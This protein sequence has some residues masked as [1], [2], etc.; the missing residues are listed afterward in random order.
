MNYGDRSATVHVARGHGGEATPVAAN[1]IWQRIDGVRKDKAKRTYVD[2]RSVQRMTRSTCGQT[3]LCSRWSSDSTRGT[4][5]A[6]HPLF[7][8]FFLYVFK[9]V[10][11]HSLK[12][13]SQRL[14]R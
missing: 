7:E 5:L 8:S 14:N 9:T 6:G 4:E 13:K 1:Q 3:L 12:Y 10:P 11:L 2:P